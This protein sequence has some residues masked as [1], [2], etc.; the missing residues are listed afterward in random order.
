MKDGT[1]LTGKIETVDE[2]RV[3]IYTAYFGKLTL[4]QSEIVSVKYLSDPKVAA[5]N[6]LFAN[7]NSSRHFFSPAAIPLSK[8]EGYYQNFY[9]AFN[10]VNWGLTEHY[11]MGVAAV[12]FMW[13]VQDGLNIA[14]TG[15][16]GYQLSSKWHAS[17]GYI[18]GAIPSYTYGGIAFGLITYGST[19][20]NFT[21]GLGYSSLWPTNQSE[22]EADQQ[23]LV[24]NTAGMYRISDHFALVSENWYFVEPDFLIIS[25]GGRYMGEKISVDVGF[26]NNKDIAS[27][28]PVGVPLLG[29]VIHL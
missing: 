23:S 2:V 14:I 4:L 21:V 9:V 17:G 11:S 1:R 6:F 19:D 29:V 15:K 5:G 12:P 7:P 20:N 25:Y 22:M 16:L 26:I 10:M 13:F 24:I 18:A 8:N 3:A 27:T 28:I